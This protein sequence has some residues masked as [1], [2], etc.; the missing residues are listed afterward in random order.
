MAGVR[1]VARLTSAGERE[2]PGWCWQGIILGC[3]DHPTP[4]Q[5][6]ASQQVEVRQTTRGQTRKPGTLTDTTWMSASFFLHAHFF[7]EKIFWVL[8]SVLFRRQM[9]IV[10][11]LKLLDSSRQKS[12]CILDRYYMRSVHSSPGKSGGQAPHQ[13][14]SV[15]GNYELLD[16]RMMTVDTVTGHQWGPASA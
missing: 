16:S 2:G 10:M 3:F 11:I 1:G 15:L 5:H 12:K 7:R 6:P 8:S 4:P 14:G 9:L 13:A